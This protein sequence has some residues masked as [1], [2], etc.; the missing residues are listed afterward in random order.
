ARSHLLLTKMIPEFEEQPNPRLYLTGCDTFNVR[1]QR[2]YPA[3]LSLGMSDQR[4]GRNANCEG[5][6]Y[7]CLLRLLGESECAHHTLQIPPRD[8][9]G[10]R[11]LLRRWLRSL[12]A[13]EEPVNG[14]AVDAPDLQKCLCTGLAHGSPTTSLGLRSHDLRQS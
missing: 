10:W 1:R 2:K 9:R 14:D 12:T 11:V 8:F 5:A 3:T 13:L 4:S 7:V 6:T